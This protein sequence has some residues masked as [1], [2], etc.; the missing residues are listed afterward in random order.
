M[1]VNARVL[2]RLGLGLATSVALAACGKGSA[3]EAATPASEVA[4]IGRA[5][6]TI[7]AEASGQVEPIREVEVKSTASGEILALHV[8]T[9]MTVPQGTLL[10]EVDPR[11][12]RNSLAQAEA[13]LTVAEQR[14]TTAAEQ[15]KRTQELRDANVVTAQELESAVL[16]QANAR[17]SIIK[18]QTNLQLAR[19]RMNDVQIRAPIAGT[20]IS[21]SVEQG[22]IIASA[23]QNISGGTTLMQMA[24]LATMQ[25]RALVD[26][27]DIGKIQP[28]M[29]TRVSVEA[30]PE[31]TFR[32][33]LYKIEPQA[34]VEQNVTMFPVLVRLD[35]PEGLLKPGMNADIAVEIAQ[36]ENALVVPNAAIVATAD[37]TA[38]GEVLGLSEESV[39]NS[40]R[41]GGN[42]GG[43][44]GEDQAVQGGG[45]AGQR[46]AAAG[47]QN[48]P[49]GPG[50]Q[51]AAPQAGGQQP[52]AP[53]ELARAGGQPGAGAPGAQ[54][55]PTAQAGGDDAKRQE[56]Q[57]LMTRIR[58]S[59]GFQNLS[60]ADRTKMRDCRSVL[61]FGQRGGNG[62]GMGGFGGQRSRN[63]DDRAV[64]VF[65]LGEQGPE[66]RRIL[67]G[68]ND[69]DNSEVISGL[70]DGD[71]VILISVARL[72]AQQEEMNQRIRER[73]GA[74]GVLSGGGMGGPGMGGPPGGG[75]G[76]AG[77]RGGR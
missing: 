2:V 23:S 31:R 64:V 77:G 71:K 61:G 19:E 11:D 49:A 69:F 21:K 42:G 63:P 36:R 40:L 37:A 62:G 47:E 50:G 44:P 6:L 53:A 5:S 8:E 52:G 67:V 41:G 51:P 45:G 43:A 46:P 74:S 30:Y 1:I 57:Q 70:K 10:A 58:E 14:A 60:E 3:D 76:G 38:A 13:D 18:A 59:G 55:A 25:V 66:A 29:S 56:C 28:G 39:Q 54:G 68:L 33:S 72:Q 24:D 17:A 22:T 12:V 20:V 32:G 75:P 27:T 4:T 15:R 65:L 34:V 73:A 9:G 48:A 26:E 35:N 7:T 16:E